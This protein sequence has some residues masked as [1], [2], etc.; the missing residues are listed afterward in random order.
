MCNI[1]KSEL[2][3]SQ[4]TQQSQNLRVAINAASDRLGR[5]TI[6]E[7]W[8]HFQA[9]ELSRLRDGE[10]E[11]GETH[12]SPTTIECHLDNYKRHIIPAWGDIAVPAP[13]VNDIV[14][15]KRSISADTA[16]R[17]GKY[18]GLPAQFWLNLQNDYDL[19]NADK[20]AVSK[21]KPLKAA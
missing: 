1:G 5:M 3:V 16:L 21:I 4:L 8:G 17:L 11:A 12:R 18:F 15:G 2:R 13:R 10:P 20:T 9:E 19:R 14:L 6:R 7:L